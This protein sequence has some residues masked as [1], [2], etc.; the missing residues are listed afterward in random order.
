MKTSNL[1]R[2]IV[3]SGFLVLL[4]MLV[5]LSCKKKDDTPIPEPTPTPKPTV[6]V[7]IFHSGFHK[8]MTDD[9]IIYKKKFAGSFLYEVGAGLRG[10]D[11]G[12]PYGECVKM[13]SE[14]HENNQT[15]DEFDKIDKQ[16]DSISAQITDLKNEITQLSQQME[17]SQSAILSQM[18]TLL[19]NTYISTI[20]TAYDSTTN[21]G[22][23]YYSSAARQ[24]QSGQYHITMAQLDSTAMKDFVPNYG[25]S[26]PGNPMPNCINQIQTLILGSPTG[27]TF[28]SSS[29]KQFADVIILN[30]N[31]P[32]ATVTYAMN[33]YKI[34]ENYFLMSV[35]SQ[36][37]A[38][39]IYGNALYRAE[40]DTTESNH[41][42]RN[43]LAGFTAIIQSELRMFLL[44]T[45]YLSVN[46]VDYRNP[47][48][49]NSDA[50]VYFNT[51]LKPD[52]VCA[53]FIARANM[54]NQLINFSLGQPTKDFYLTISVPRNYGN[55]A[56]LTWTSSPGTYPL[57]I[58]NGGSLISRYPY[59]GWSTAPQQVGTCSA[60]NNITFYRDNDGTGGS[61]KVSLGNITIAING[62]P[63]R[64]ISK[65]QGNASVG[66]YN[67]ND[68][69]ATPQSSYSS[70][71]CLAFG[72][73]SSC[74]YWGYLWLNDNAANNMV[75]A[76]SVNWQ[77]PNGN[78][79][80]H[81]H[82]S[83]FMMEN[84]DENDHT[85]H[86][87]GNFYWSYNSL[88]YSGTFPT[89]SKSDWLLTGQLR[90]AVINVSG[91]SA[92]YSPS[93]NIYFSYSLIPFSWTES[94]EYYF[95]GTEINKNWTNASLLNNFQTSST[96]Y[97]QSSVSTATVGAGEHTFN[98][99]FYTLNPAET[100][101]FNS[102]SITWY[103]QVIYGGTYN[104]TQ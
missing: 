1:L 84:D 24:I 3:A 21:G 14:I 17:I 63:W 41:D 7:N 76:T 45:D 85:A 57:T 77:V 44:V 12:I 97:A 53:S 92:T 30:Q 61:T 91:S 79:G 58:D 65:L 98:V 95:A 70:T 69:T 46:L 99:G 56:T 62:A 52:E 103:G 34:L 18:N 96:K 8:M 19:T 32:Q 16:L 43:F 26:A 93:N 86:Y 28:A 6:P 87:G 2:K 89:T 104:I 51:G 11:P 81:T 22:L 101:N 102:C 80:E 25:P 36:F 27:P 49:F 33:C 59:T 73:V 78:S 39:T 37:R 5:V 68:I 74:W 48:I 35:N 20:N 38:F 4:M 83:V 54:L 23:C 60:D 82:N 9:E 72:S 15:K 10:E 88:G 71:Y 55:S 47:W 29:I 66:Y 31:S 42:Y 100:G 75:Q 40:T 50:Q 64:Q 90:S 13:L 94:D 67:P